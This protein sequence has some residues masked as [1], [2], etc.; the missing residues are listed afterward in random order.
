MPRLLPLAGP[1]LLAPL[2]LLAGCTSTPTAEP[3]AAPASDACTEVQVSYFITALGLE[4]ES[5]LA[6]PE[7]EGYPELMGD[8]SC[9]FKVEDK[10]IGVYLAGSQDK[11][12]AIV[13]DWTDAGFIATPGAAAEG[14]IDSATFSETEG[15]EQL[16]SLQY[17]ES[18]ADTVPGGDF[19]LAA[20][21]LETE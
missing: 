15:G 1:L 14:L 21:T 8:P 3:T 16:A 7:E 4:A 18:G 17:G 5:Q 12:D 13:A 2:L 10:Y 9:A 20:G 6:A 11:F 19:M